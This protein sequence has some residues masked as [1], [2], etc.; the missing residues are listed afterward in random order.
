M[1]KDIAPSFSAAAG[2]HQ[3]QQPDKLSAPY[4]FNFLK[5]QRS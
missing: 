3:G 1:S 4:R 5:E 2:V